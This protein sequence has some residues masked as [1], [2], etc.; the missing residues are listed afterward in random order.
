MK[1]S[2]FSLDLRKYHVFQYYVIGIFASNEIYCDLQIDCRYCNAILRAET[3]SCEAAEWGAASFAQFNSSP[4]LW[5]QEV[6]EYER[7]FGFNKYILHLLR[8]MMPRMIDF[9][10]ILK[11]YKLIW[12]AYT[13]HSYAL[14]GIYGRNTCAPPTA[15]TTTKECKASYLTFK[16]T[17]G[18]RPCI[19]R[20]V[21]FNILKK[22]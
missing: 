4:L 17:A 12:A 16:N 14:V 18:L 21:S 1:L 19:T 15:R 22:L 5:S 7:T 3:E 11:V 9:R 8:C 20:H 6:C 13:S 10:V 2:Y